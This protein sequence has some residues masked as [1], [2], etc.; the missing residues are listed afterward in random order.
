MSHSS[1]VWLRKLDFWPSTLEFAGSS[2]ASVSLLTRSQNMHVSFIEK[3]ILFRGVNAIVHSYL[4]LYVRCDLLVT[5][6]KKN[7]IK[8]NKRLVKV[9]TGTQP[10]QKIFS[11]HKI[12]ALFYYRT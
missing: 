2:R 7:K 10:T 12:G 1:E 6:I 4:R 9:E 8:I 11:A 5:T 3:A